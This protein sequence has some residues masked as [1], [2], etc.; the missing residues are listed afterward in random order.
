MEAGRS[1]TAIW[2][3]VR[4]PK[5][6]Q[7]LAV[8]AASTKATNSSD[9]KDFFMKAGID[10]AGKARGPAKVRQRAPHLC[11]GCFL[12]DWDFLPYPLTH[13]RLLGGRGRAGLVRPV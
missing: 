5:K 3:M 12:A 2:V 10:L 13:Q 8:P 9:N 1:Y 6:P 7:P 4:W 11:S